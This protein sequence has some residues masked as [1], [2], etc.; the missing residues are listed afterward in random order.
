[1]ELAAPR[2]HGYLGLQAEE[3]TLAA[4][5]AKRKHDVILVYCPGRYER[6]EI[7]PPAQWI[8]HTRVGVSRTALELGH[9]LV[10]LERA[11]SSQSSDFNSL[12]P[13]GG[14]RLAGAYADSAP[15]AFRTTPRTVKVHPDRLEASDF[16]DKYSTA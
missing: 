9:W 10:V 11:S 12:F 2:L 15:F 1:M 14:G 5:A 16:G 8:W 7:V 3:A 13:I 6:K 4:G